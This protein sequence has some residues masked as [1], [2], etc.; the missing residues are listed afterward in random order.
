M[1]RNKFPFIYRLHK[2]N[3]F[4]RISASKHYVNNKWVTLYFSNNRLP[5]SRLGVIVAKR[6]SGNAVDRNY[7][8][9]LV[10]NTF[11]VIANTIY[12]PVDIV[13]K[14]NRHLIRS[15][16]KLFCV[17]LEF[18][19]KDIARYLPDKINDKEHSVINGEILPIPDKPSFSS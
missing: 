14:F 8:K 4:R 12:P 19:L 6:V 10:K 3:D 9:R 18:L 13:V 17:A 5:Y 16:S 15:E 11:R 1:S 2:P 7:A